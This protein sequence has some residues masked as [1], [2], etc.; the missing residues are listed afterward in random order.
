MAFKVTASNASNGSNANNVASN[1]SNSTSQPESKAASIAKATAEKMKA[2][3]NRP[4]AQTFIR[5]MVILE[6]GM[7]ATPENLAQIEKGR[8]ALVNRGVQSF[9]KSLT[10]KLEKA[11]RKGKSLDNPQVIVKNIREA[12]DETQSTK[13]IEARSNALKSEC[14]Q[15]QTSGEKLAE[16]NRTLTKCARC[17]ETMYCSKECQTTAWPSHK[18]VCKKQEESAK[19]ASVRP[20]NLDMPAQPSTFMDTLTAN[21]RK[22]LTPQNSDAKIIEILQS[23]GLPTGP[24][25][26]AAWREGEQEQAEKMIKIFSQRLN[27]QINAAQSTGTTLNLGTLYRLAASTSPYEDNAVGNK[28]SKAVDKKK[29]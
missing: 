8:Q 27:M 4:I 9:E 12:A 19:K 22:N 26:V 13:K 24:E 5:E 6:T 15:C 25:F 16:L 14:A 1:A 20:S 10:Q 7:S 11:E 18:L 29:E 3:Q 23:R 17:R 21:I 2:L 28:P